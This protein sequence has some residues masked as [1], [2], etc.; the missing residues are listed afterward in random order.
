MVSLHTRLKGIEG[1]NESF[2]ICVSSFNEMMQGYSHLPGY[3]ETILDA[4]EI[5][6][7]E[8]QRL[9]ILDYGRN[10]IVRDALEGRSSVTAQLEDLARV[11]RSVRILLPR[12]RNEAH[13]QRVDLMKEVIESE[14]IPHLDRL[15]TR[16][17]LAPDNFIN[18]FVYGVSSLVPISLGL[19]YILEGDGDFGATLRWLDEEI[20]RDSLVRKISMVIGGAYG[21]SG[22]FIADMIGKRTGGQ[23]YM[24]NAQY[25]DDK[26]TEL[27]SLS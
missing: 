24:E 27:F 11:N 8:A 9:T 6:I 4:P 14:D 18:G 15:K 25:V 17:F 7:P 13:N 23:F 26:I 5:D 10:P 3:R 1:L 20:I 19:A 2:Q 16:R 12:R 22:A 21:L